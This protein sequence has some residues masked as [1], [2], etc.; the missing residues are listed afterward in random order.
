MPSPAEAGDLTQPTSQDY[1]GAILKWQFT[2]DGN[3]RYINAIEIA[4]F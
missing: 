2:K 3:W 4:L 1:V